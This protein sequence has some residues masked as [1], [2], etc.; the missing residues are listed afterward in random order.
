MF[1]A[2]KDI[3]GLDIGSQQVKIVQLRESKGSYRLE[4]LAVAALQPELIVDGSILDATRVVEIIRELIMSSDIKTKDV[5]LSVSGHSS[6]I[7]KRVALPQMSEDE[8]EESIRF[9]A[10]QYI[11]FDIEDVNLD[12]QILGPAEEDN[13]MDVLIVAVK[14]DKI[15]E[16]VSVVKEAGLNPVIVDVDAFA[17]E[18]MYEL[19]YEVKE[20]ENVALVNIGASMININILKGGTS[21]FT[22]DSSVGGNLLTEALQKEFTISYANAE[23]LKQ[24]EAL[25]GISP[26]DVAVVLNAASEDII[27]EISRSFDY[28]RDTTNYENIDEIIV[29]GGSTLI[30]GIVSSLE[31]RSGITVRVAE[32][33]KNVDVPDMFDK[34]YVK[35]VEPLVAVAVGLALR[36]VGD[37]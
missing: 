28:F 25:E 32:P 1:F 7:I 11:P 3:I 18:N 24:E 16:Y 4:K 27:T 37:K 13:M 21:V 8:L 35:K 29:S 34:D 31:E 22:R 30:G 33:F 10:E 2:K 36:R 26:E 20:N 23:K 14:K 17:L 5:T 19:N 9:E 12:F 6:V 15:N